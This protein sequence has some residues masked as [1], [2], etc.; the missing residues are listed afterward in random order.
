[1]YTI[2]Y[3]AYIMAMHSLAKFFSVLEMTREQQ[4]YGFF[5]AGLN[6]K[7]TSNLAEH[8]YLSAMIGWLLAEYINE[9]EQ[10]VNADEILRMCLVHDIG[11]LFGGDIAA[12]LSRKRPDM[13][14]HARALEAANLDII[15]SLLS[16]RL[17]EVVKA[18]H[19]KAEAKQTDEAIVAKLADLIETHFFLEHRAINSAQKE[20]FYQNHIKPLAS[21]AGSPKVRAKLEEFLVGFE[22]HV[23]DKGFTAGN[24]VMEL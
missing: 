9:A 11:E 19:A 24:W 14:V 22:E 7:N 5:I 3:N 17:N 12:P 4:Q 15:T 21:S 20:P 2:C 16:P 23:K 18:I 1:M 13:K 6:N 8:H 10:L